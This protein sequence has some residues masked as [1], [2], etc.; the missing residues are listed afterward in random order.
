MD[1]LIAA[2][3]TQSVLPSEG[4][5]GPK[6]ACDRRIKATLKC[7]FEASA[8]ALRAATMSLL[9]RATCLWADEMKKS[10]RKLRMSLAAVFSS[11]E[12]LDSLKFVSRAMAHSV[13]ARR[14][15]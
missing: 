6:D 3:S 7:C 11:D 15:I 13:T 4:E 14:N 5:G 9:S 2:L 10:A 12:S 8:Y 1:A